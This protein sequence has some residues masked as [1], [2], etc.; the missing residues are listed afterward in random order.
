MMMERRH[1]TI[2]EVGILC[3]LM[4]SSQKNE[5]IYAYK[6][7][8]NQT[9]IDYFMIQRKDSTNVKNCKVILGEPITPQHRVLVMDYKIN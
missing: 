6:S 5:K 4:P 3:W 1:Y 9:V 8:L 7:G 2:Q